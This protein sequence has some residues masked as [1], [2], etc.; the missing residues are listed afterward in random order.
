MRIPY[1]IRFGKG[2]M[3]AMDASRIE[4]VLK[5]AVES[6]IFPGCAWAVGH[7]GKVWTGVAGRHGYC[8]DTP[9]VTADTVWDLAS[10]SKVVGT[11]SA[12][13]LLVEEGKLDL[14][15]KVAAILPGFEQ[16]GKGDVT[17]RNLLLHD[18]GF[19][20]FRAFHQRLNHRSEVEK[21][22][23]AEKPQYERGSKAVYSDLGIIS[24]G[25][26]IEAKSGES[27]DGLLRRRVFTPLAM[28]STLYN[29][30]PLVRSKCAPTEPVEA[31]RSRVR[32]AQARESDE[33]R[34]LETLPDGVRYIRG[35]VHDPTATAFGG[36]A[37]HAGLFST[38]GDLARFMGAMVSGGGG[39]LKPETIGLFTRR[40]SDV[41]SRALGWDTNWKHDA[42]AGP[43]WAETAFGHTGY[44]GTSVWGD[45]QRG[46]FAVLLTNRVHPTAA[47]TKIIPWRKVFHS[48]VATALGISA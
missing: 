47:N 27:L 31:W 26:V 25:L 24:L 32:K 41:S 16:G 8:P 39:V 18:S 10:V 22:I 29:P 28:G 42:S 23:L 17:V 6:G 45:A 7:E 44:T 38:V 9:E 11:T 35:E 14:N 37:G 12:A 19:A 4:D 46:L 1:R 20:A 15:E 40:A 43:N 33:V 13:A 48:A 5:E 34:A 30:A 2:R 36:V 21:A 3:K